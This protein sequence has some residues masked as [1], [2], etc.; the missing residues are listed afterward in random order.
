MAELASSF[1]R[2]LGH[3]DFDLA[4]VD[5]I[6][7]LNCPIRDCSAALVN[8]VYGKQHDSAG[9]P[10][11]K[12]KPWCP[13]HGIRLHSGTFVYWSSEDQRE[14]S[15]LRNF[16]V[17]DDLVTKIAFEAGSK[18]EAHRLGHEMSEDALSWN[19]FVSF[20]VAGKLKE[21]GEW[22][23]G[24]SLSTEPNLY[25]WGQRIDIEGGELGT[26]PAL[27]E[28]REH[29]ESGIKHF[30]TEPDIMLVIE[31]EIVICIEAKFGSGNPLAYDGNEREG[32]KPTSRAGLFAKYL[33]KARKPRTRVAIH[34]KT[35]A[36]TL[37]S[38][39]FRNVVFASEMAEKDWH[40]VNLVRSTDQRTKDSARY[41]FADP[42]ADVKSYLS[43]DSQSC[44][45][46]RTWE[47]L[48]AAVIKGT[49]ELAELG[50]YMRGKSAHYRPAFELT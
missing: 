18:A 29:L 23:T 40:V 20:A 9:K 5:A 38:Q 33:G 14:D 46:Y 42:S 15:R 17:R 43:P 1:T 19:V 31:G 39:L 50:S 4:R 11:R 10:T 7:G 16:I 22:L 49:P 35:K 2:Q 47:N 41:S 13:V 24:R 34:S 27:L 8:L 25:L 48:Y 6:P 26:Y 44:F 28:A 21:A 37:H 30:G 12:T 32:K 3:A 45:T 36:S